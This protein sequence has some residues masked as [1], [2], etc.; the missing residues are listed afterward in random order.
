MAMMAGSS[1]HTHIRHPWRQEKHRKHWHGKQIFTV[2]D[3][4]QVDREFLHGAN[5]CFCNY[6]TGKCKN[7]ALVKSICSHSLFKNYA[8]LPSTLITPSTQGASLIVSS[9]WLCGFDMH[10][11][12][13]HNS[14]HKH[15]VDSK[16]SWLLTLWCC[17]TALAGGFV[18]AVGWLGLGCFGMTAVFLFSVFGHNIR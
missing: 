1:H 2:R 5:Y 4:Q 16:E 6:S 13:A 18:A 11:Y 7:N 8:V 9:K 3:F 12:A 14:Q 17:S 15:W 10:A